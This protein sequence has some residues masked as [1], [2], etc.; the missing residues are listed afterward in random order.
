M[1]MTKKERAEVDALILKAETL[2]ALRWTSPATR[3]VLPPKSGYTEGWDF[4][5]HGKR[6]WLGWSGVTNHGTGAAPKLSERYKS[7]S[8]NSRHMH[9]TEALALAAMRHE[10]ELLAAADL[11]AIDRRIALLPNK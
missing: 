4:N 9:S 6:V 5:A 1:A 7:A 11:L 3:D 8:Q 10:I 2:A